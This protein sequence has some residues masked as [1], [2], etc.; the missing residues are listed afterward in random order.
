M[1]AAE[2]PSWFLAL[3]TSYGVVDDELAVLPL[4]LFAVSRFQGVGDPTHP[5]VEGPVDEAQWRAPASTR[6]WAEVVG[7]HG[8]RT[9][10]VLDGHFTAETT[11]AEVGVI[12]DACR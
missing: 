6:V 4:V 3:G 7:T 12:D 5:V 11:W 8:L 1:L 9:L 10:S 2:V